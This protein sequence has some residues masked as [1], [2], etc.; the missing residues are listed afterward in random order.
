MEL[1]SIIIVLF[2]FIAL[3][4]TLSKFRTKKISRRTSI[5]W[6][7][8]WISLMILAIIPGISSTIAREIGVQRGSDVIIYTAIFIIFYLLL[9]LYSKIEKVEKEITVLVRKIAIKEENN[10]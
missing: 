7:L 1:F 6:N 10:K 9:V 2:S 5:L 8:I 3:L 4:L